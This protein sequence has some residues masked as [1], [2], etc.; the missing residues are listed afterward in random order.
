VGDSVGND[1]GERYELQ[2]TSNVSQ[3]TLQQMNQCRLLFLFH[4]WQKDNIDH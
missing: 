1:I 2:A 4:I 3:I